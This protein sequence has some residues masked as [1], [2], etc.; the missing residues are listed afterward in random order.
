MRMTRDW[1]ISIDSHF[2]GNFSLSFLL[3]VFLFSWTVGIH[4]L[5]HSLLFIRIF[6]LVGS[7]HHY[8]CHA[9]TAD[10]CTVAA[11]PRPTDG[12]ATPGTTV[13][14]TVDSVNGG[15]CGVDINAPG[16][17]WSFIGTGTKIR[18]SS[19]DD[20][21]AIKVKMSVF[22]G[23]CDA[24]RCV[25]GGDAPDFECPTS[26]GST[27][28]TLATAIEFDTFANQTY[29]VLVQNAGS[30][31]G[32]VWV[33]FGPPNLPQSNNCVDAIGPVPRDNTMV[34]A[35]SIEATLDVVEA[36]SCGADHVYPGVWF[37]F[38]GTG[39]SVTV[40][41]CA[42][43]NYDGFTFS[44]YHAPDC[45]QLV[46]EST[47]SGTSISNDDPKCV[48]GTALAQTPMSSTSVQ[49]K[50]MDRYYVLVSYSSTSGFPV[51]S[52]FRFYVDDGEGGKAGA[53]AISFT[54]GVGSGSGNNGNND[55]NGGKK[56]SAV[57][58]AVATFVGA[59]PLVG[60]ALL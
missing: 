49:T 24:L 2:F 33:K 50:V 3:C 18:A 20:S 31:S 48:F 37:Q 35:T 27:L 6:R 56:D 26:D 55:N 22:T 28:N 45:D 39:K 53:K 51:T 25:T 1:A 16:V 29:Y 52:D 19:C 59:L 34:L 57:A 12:R 9:Q 54:G 23:S 41:A 32:I 8:C 43:T 7:D 14:A 17:W 60:M 42:E 21:T 40:S 38:M 10:D 11:G 44:V 4:N 47:A 15:F 36:G 46:C 30:E 13:G 5:W 58:E